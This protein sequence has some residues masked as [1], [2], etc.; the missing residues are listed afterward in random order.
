MSSSVSILRAA[1]IAGY[2]EAMIGSG[3]PYDLCAAGAT[4]VGTRL[5]GLA[6]GR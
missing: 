5:L 2:T 3:G 4:G 6:P 1:D